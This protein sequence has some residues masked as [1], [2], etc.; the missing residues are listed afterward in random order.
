MSSDKPELI[1]SAPADRSLAAYQQWVRTL[2]A[3]FGAENDDMTPAEWE[4]DWR[5][6]WA[7]E[8]PAEAP[9]AA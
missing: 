6:F 4:A 8:L 5:A 3:T 9:D 7:D 1:L 2:A